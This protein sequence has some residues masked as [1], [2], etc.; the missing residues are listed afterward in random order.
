M[1]VSNDLSWPQSVDLIQL[2]AI[3][4]HW[5]LNFLLGLKE[6]FS[7]MSD[8]FQIVHV[9]KESSSCNEL[10]SLFDRILYVDQ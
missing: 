2:T 3:F 6:L 9:N 4:S 1:E 8:R 5:D 7:Y 10:V